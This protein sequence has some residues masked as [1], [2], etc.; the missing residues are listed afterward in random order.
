MIQIKRLMCLSSWKYNRAYVFQQTYNPRFTFSSGRYQRNNYM[1]VIEHY[2][3]TRLNIV[4]GQ[5]LQNVPQNRNRETRETFDFLDLLQFNIIYGLV[6]FHNTFKIISIHGTGGF[7]W[8][9]PGH[10]PLHRPRIFVSIVC[11]L[12]QGWGVLTE[13]SKKCSRGCWRSFLSK[14]VFGPPHQQ[15][16]QRVSNCIV[17]ITALG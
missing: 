6:H 12:A 17:P 7:R 11:R 8:S 16:H 13:F 14:N 3:F 5:S 1:D 10:G 4:I 9:H 2:S 15:N